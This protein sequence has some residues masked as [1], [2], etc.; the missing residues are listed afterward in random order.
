MHLENYGIYKDLVENGEIDINTSILNTTNIDDHFKWIHNILSDGIEKPEIQSLKIHITFVD[1]VKINLFIEDYMFNL[2][3]WSISLSA[4]HP[5]SSFY[6]FN[7]VTEPVTKGSIKKWIDQ[8][9]IAI[10]LKS[11]DNIHMNQSIDRGIYKFTLLENFQMYL[12][13]TVNLEDTIALME[14]YPEFNDT[15]HFDPTGIPI[16]DVKEEGMKATNIQINYIKNSDHCLKDAF[17]AGE[18]INAKQYKEV[19]VNI[20]PKPDGQG[21]VFPHPIMGSFINGGLKN[22]EEII[23][24]SSIGRIAQILQKQNVGQSGAFARNLGLNN[25]DSSLY[26]DPDYVCNTRNFEVIE[27]VNK[28]MLDELN[29]RY[30]RTNPRGIDYC[31]NASKD[32][33]LIGQTIYL[34]SPMTCA[35]AARGQGICYKCYGDLAYV[36]RDINIGQ[37]ASEQLSAV[38][39]Q[40]L[41]SAKHLLESAIV[42]MNWTEGFF[43]VF[44]VEYNQITFK[45][46]MNYRGYKLIINDYYDDDDEEGDNGDLTTYVNS[47]DIKFPD[48]GIVTMRTTSDNDAEFDQIFIHDELLEYMQ[49]VGTVDDESDRY[50]LDLNKMQDL[51]ALFVVEVKNNELSKTMK[52]IKNIID[53]KKITK[54]YDR[55]SILSDFITTNLAG[56][57]KMDSVHFEVLLMNQIRAAD[58]ILELPDWSLENEPCQ[59][60]TLNES[61]TNNRSI[62]V[63]L[64]SSK[65]A[66]T[67]TSPSNRQLSQP[68]NMDLFYMEQ[69]QKFMT[70]EYVKSTY[71]PNKKNKR[72]I[73]KPL[74][75]IVDDTE[76]K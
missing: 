65:I 11:M 22:A 51:S 41:L 25:Q 8:K 30:Y 23:V 1:D 57:I 29:M 2:I 71:D 43:N 18:G 74:Y 7:C 44:D 50:E 31:I 17:I 42:K 13:N 76:I 69:P 68:S 63:R 62:S 64:Q 27:I 59:I 37:I 14:K 10:N 26:P 6:F 40:T 72:V 48:G 4:N 34:R 16:E 55:N 19:S 15:V 9:F 39:T 32:K 54:S 20:G 46:D 67:L 36:N 21:G 61:L 35:S 73:K 49:R 56:N 28:D 53:N 47:F 70:D 24:E 5:V 58:D 12:A 45:E 52:S 38:Y 33:H 60:L 75:K 3:F 66:R